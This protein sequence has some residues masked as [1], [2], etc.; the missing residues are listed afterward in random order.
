MRAAGHEVTAPGQR[1]DP[2]ELGAP[3]DLLRLGAMAKP[4]RENPRPRARQA[5]VF[6]QSTAL[7]E[8]PGLWQRWRWRRQLER[9]D[10]L[11]LPSEAARR[12]W[13]ESGFA[14]ER[15]KLLLPGA[16]DPCRGLEG[17]RPSPLP[18]E[19]L[20]IVSARDGK[21]LIWA[22]RLERVHPDLE[23]LI[24]DPA[25]G[26]SD[27][28]PRATRSAFLISAG[29]S[30]LDALLLVDALGLA[31]PVIVAPTSGHA[32]LV[33][34]GA[35]W[36]RPLDWLGDDAFRDCIEAGSAQHSELRLAA[37]QLFRNR[38][39]PEAYGLRLTT[40]FQRALVSAPRL[41]KA[42]SRA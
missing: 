21:G 16:E 25:L 24:V 30:L 28:L 14:P 10:W 12:R 31:V 2:I 40:L 26:L 20:M 15:M 11:L 33:I 18:A 6:Q 23:L 41:N 35:G 3:L 8:E 38:Y 39:S 32:D 1:R 9:V 4:P 5:A 36:R 19:S 37:R 42:L 7:P 13:L 17:A 22:R 27:A 34:D 29:Q